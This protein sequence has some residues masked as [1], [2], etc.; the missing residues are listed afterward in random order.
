M[1]PSIGQV[2]PRL[3]FYLMYSHIRLQTHLD[4]HRESLLI[5]LYVYYHNK[6]GPPPPD[7]PAFRPQCM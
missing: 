3:H 5:S 2:H 4:L 6:F 7:P 1:I